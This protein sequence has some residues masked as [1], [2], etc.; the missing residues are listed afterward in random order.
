MG[1]IVT[2]MIAQQ[3]T[4]VN[5][6]VFEDFTTIGGFFLKGVGKQETKEGD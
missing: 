3:K 4:N 5:N 1:P 6:R 2:I